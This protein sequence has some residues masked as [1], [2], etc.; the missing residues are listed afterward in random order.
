MTIN[1]A[2]NSPRIEYSVAQG[3]TQTTFTVPFEFFDT[4]DIN[5]YVDGTLKVEGSDYTVTGGEGST[6]SIIFV[7]ADPGETQQVTGATGGS[8]VVI[9]RDIPIE[10]T[11]DFNAGSDINRAALNEQLDT[12]IALIADVDDKAS[13]TIQLT[14]YDIPWDLTLPNKDSLKGNV[15]AFHATTGSPIVGPTVNEVL[16]AEEYSVQSAASA[17]AAASSASAAASS[18]SSAA[19]SESAAA[20]SESNAAISAS[21]AS[22]SETNAATSETNAATSASA[23]STSASNASTSE[24]NAAASASAAAGSASAASTSETNAATSESNAAT[25]ATNAANSATAAA[26]S[27]ASAA[28]AAIIYAIALG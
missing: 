20:T 25:S 18:A 13:R 17:S 19:A 15:L 10:R 27:A 21:A 23:A 11:T 6:G 1:A 5:V 24:T 28:N 12:I 7:V 22:T 3:V 2:D 14:D 16:N 9:T 4:G 26:A 8:Q